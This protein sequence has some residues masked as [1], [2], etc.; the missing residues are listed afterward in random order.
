MYSKR[1][2]TTTLTWPLLYKLT[3]NFYA[4]SYCLNCLSLLCLS[5][6]FTRQTSAILQL[7]RMFQNGCKASSK[8]NPCRIPFGG[9]PFLKKGPL[10]LQK[11]GPFDFPFDKESV[12]RICMWILGLKSITLTL[13][14]SHYHVTDTPLHKTST[15]IQLQNLQQKLNTFY[16]DKFLF[17]IK[18]NFI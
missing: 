3:L 12:W 6:Y 9:P 2:L 8:R 14:A 1:S 16:Q 10:K 13:Q 7:P 15:N 4:A 17:A 18:T 5:H 11:G